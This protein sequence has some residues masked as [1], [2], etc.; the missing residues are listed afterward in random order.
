MPTAATPTSNNRMISPVSVPTSLAAP[1][2]YVP[3]IIV[4]I[5]NGHVVGIFPTFRVV[6]LQ[7][8]DRGRAGENE[9]RVAP[10][11]EVDDGGMISLTGIAELV[12]D[13]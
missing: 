5:Q 6:V 2:A 7:W 8:G 1:E 13:G 12:L 4:P 9:R 3:A 11:T 10:I